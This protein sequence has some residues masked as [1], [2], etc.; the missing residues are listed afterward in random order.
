MPGAS[1]DQIERE[2][3]RLV[4]QWVDPNTGKLIIAKIDKVDPVTGKITKLVAA[5]NREL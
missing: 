4:S 2:K 3:N 5:T 1:E